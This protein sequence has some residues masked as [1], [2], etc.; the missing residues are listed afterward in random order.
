MRVL[1][2]NIGSSSLKFD[3]VDST[4]AISLFSGSITKYGND[5]KLVLKSIDSLQVVEQT[6]R[7]QNAT[8]G[9][10]LI[11]KYIHDAKIEYDAIGFRVVHGGN[12]DYHLLLTND[13]L[14]QLKTYNDLAPLHNPQTIEAIKKCSM[15]TD[16]PI[17]LIFDTVFF[18]SLQPIAYTY[19]VPLRWQE[20][21]VRKYGFHGINHEYLINSLEKQGY[22]EKVITCHLGAG[23]SVTATKDGVAVDT[24]MG[25]TP[26]SGIMMATRSGDLDPAID[27]YMMKKLNMSIEEVNYQLSNESGIKGLVG[28]TDIEKVIQL[29]EDG[30]KN[31]LLAI[32]MFVKRIIEYI[33]SY[34]VFMGGCDALVFSGGVGENSPIIRKQVVTGLAVLGF[35]LDEDANVNSQLKINKEGTTPEIFVMNENEAVMIAKYTSNLIKNKPKFS[36]IEML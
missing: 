7:C 5:A 17:A 6:V 35:E 9:V 11:V 14:E 3:I 20:Y 34:Y 23:S 24:S 2:L 26:T 10:G 30:H 1:V 31:A 19:P 18:K 12:F 36:N 28:E 21:G 25:F 4:K 8:E 13:I 16:K 29:A 32:N 22:F 33:S 27:N 15:I